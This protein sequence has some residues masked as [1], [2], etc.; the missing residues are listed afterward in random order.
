MQAITA[1]TVIAYITHDDRP[2]IQHETY[3]ERQA[4]TE[5]SD[6]AAC[7]MHMQYVATGSRSRRSSFLHNSVAR[8]TKEYMPPV[9]FPTG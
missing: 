3:N 7:V 9:I 8:R 1:D 6:V 2:N 4:G 5:R